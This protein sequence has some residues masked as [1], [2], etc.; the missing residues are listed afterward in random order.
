MLF[1]T[2]LL[3]QLLLSYSSIFAKLQLTSFFFSL[4]RGR[5]LCFLTR[6]FYLVA[7]FLFQYFCKIATNK[8]LCAFLGCTVVHFLVLFS[9]TLGTPRQY[10]VRAHPC[11]WHRT[12][13]FL[14]ARC[15]REPVS[16]LTTGFLFPPH[17][18]PKVSHANIH[19]AII[20]HTF[21]THQNP[22]AHF[23]V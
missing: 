18:L 9:H 23:L 12:R 1:D 8:F 14:E 13:E 17:F 15:S 5:K 22:Q 2:F 3:F 4:T 6:F 16:R 21:L 7:T 20:N 11:F 19:W 10:V